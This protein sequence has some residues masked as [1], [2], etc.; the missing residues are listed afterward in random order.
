MKFTD[1]N[2]ID[3]EDF[4]ERP[5]VYIKLHRNK[6]GAYNKVAYN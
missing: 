1:P 5:K 3:L 6:N 2:T 4:Q